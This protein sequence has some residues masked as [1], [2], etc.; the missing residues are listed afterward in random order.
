MRR[1]RRNKNTNSDF[2]DD[3]GSRR[4]RSRRSR[5]RR[6]STCK[7]LLRYRCSQLTIESTQS[8]YEEEEEYSTKT[9]QY[10]K[11]ADE[12]ADSLLHTLQVSVG[13]LSPMNSRQSYEIIQALPV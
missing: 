1:S 12:I 8:A 10:I 5:E 4:R 11:S 3:S 13:T 6:S 7:Q 2:D 9:S